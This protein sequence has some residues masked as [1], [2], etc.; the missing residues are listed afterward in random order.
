MIKLTFFAVTLVMSV[1]G[2]S[3]D[4]IM[5]LDK[6]EIKAKIL[7]ITP[8][9]VKYKDIDNIDGPTYSILK[10]HINVIVFAN[11]KIESFI[12]TTKPVTD[13]YNKDSIEIDVV[14]LVSEGAKGRFTLLDEDNKVLKR[15]QSVKDITPYLNRYTEIAPALK[16]MKNANRF[17]N[18]SDLALLTIFFGGTA[19]TIATKSY[20]T[21]L[22]ELN[23]IQTAILA[24]MGVVT[25]AKFAIVN[26][27]V[28]KRGKKLAETYNTLKNNSKIV[29]IGFSGNGIGL[30]INF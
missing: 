20:N 24:T 14:K 10:K 25:I 30:A 27:L 3:Q 21:K 2:Y 19:Y 13:A 18:I 1:M 8:E 26:P 9:F 12:E 28:N 6:T 11:G 16:K 5:K 23:G 4:K 29:K 7:E 15:N 17:S 22:N